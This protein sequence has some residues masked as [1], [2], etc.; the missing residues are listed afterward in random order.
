VW[1]PRLEIKFTDPDPQH[2]WLA[3]LNR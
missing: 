3:G 2:E 1:R